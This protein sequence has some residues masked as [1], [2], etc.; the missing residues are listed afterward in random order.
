MVGSTL[1]ALVPPI[2]EAAARPFRVG[3]LVAVLLPVAFKEGMRQ[4]TLKG[5]A[6]K[7]C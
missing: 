4:A 2:A 7:H 1:T 6:S 5:P 3:A